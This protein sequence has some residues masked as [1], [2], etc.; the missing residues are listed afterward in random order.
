MVIAEI[1]SWLSSN[2][3]YD[4]GLRILKKY[5][6]SPL[7]KMLD[8][9]ADSMNRKKLAEMLIQIE[10]KHKSIQPPPN[11]KKEVVKPELP[12]QNL[13]Y[14]PKLLR[15][16]AERKSLYAEVNHLKSKTPSCPEGDGLKDLAFELLD[17]WNRIDELWS[18]QD[19]FN[20]TGE[21]PVD[22]ADIL[23]EKYSD[24]IF[25]KKSQANL[26]SNISKISIKLKK[27]AGDPARI[28]ELTQRREDFK[29]E[30]LAVELKL[31][32][33]EKKSV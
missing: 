29:R 10:A 14:P 13:T 25:L 17:R 15:L 3:N 8:L 1:H 33:H 24:P 16:I 5:S 28:K 20:Q 26:R 22:P 2:R 23:Q 19:N 9:G 27:A 11:A 18:I 31:E 4:E 30:L 32:E 6:K 12:K 21:M 7:L